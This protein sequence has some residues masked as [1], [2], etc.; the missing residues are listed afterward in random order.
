MQSPVL[1]PRRFQ[2][3]D[4]LRA[5]AG[6]ARFAERHVEVLGTQL[7]VLGAFN[8]PLGRDLDGAVHPILEERLARAGRTRDQRL[9]I[10]GSDRVG[11]EKVSEI[12]LPEL[13][14][15]WAQ[16]DALADPAGRS[17]IAASVRSVVL[18]V[19]TK[20]MSSVRRRPFN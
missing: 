2:K 19:K 7:E 18:G 17:L 1:R 20:P 14:L 8:N 4:D 15:G 11:R 16:V 12:A 5:L 13:P 6:A 9:H 3:T 10:H